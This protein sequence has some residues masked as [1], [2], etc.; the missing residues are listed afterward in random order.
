[1]PKIYNETDVYQEAILR[2]EYTFDNFERVYLSLSGGKDS[3]VMLHIA[4]DVARRKNKKFGVMIVDLEGQY[5]L[6]IE[7]MSELVKEYQDVMELYWICLPIHLRNAVSV[8]EPFWKCWDKEAK[9]AWIRELPEQA[10]TIVTGKQ[11]QYNSMTS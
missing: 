5:E 9:D 11:I 10:I 1:M 6:T 2:T 3:T 4:A 7:H 8:Y